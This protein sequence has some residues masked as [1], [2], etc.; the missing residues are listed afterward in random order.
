MLGFIRNISSSFSSID[1]LVTSTLCC[2]LVRSELEFSYVA[3]NSVTLTV[4]L[5]SKEFKENLPIYA[6]IDFSLTLAP[7]NTNKFWLG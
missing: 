2:A 3:W 1:T 6:T 4:P 5:K 7:I